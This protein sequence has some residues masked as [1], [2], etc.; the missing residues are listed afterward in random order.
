MMCLHFVKGGDIWPDWE[1]ADP[2]VSS[3]ELSFNDHLWN[4][5][6][7]CY[8]TIPQD[9]LD[10]IEQT[11]EIAYVPG[12][13]SSLVSHLQ[14]LLSDHYAEKLGFV[15]IAS[16]EQTAAEKEMRKFTKLQVAQATWQAAFATGVLYCER[17]CQQREQK[18]RS[19]TKH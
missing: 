12:L 2:V 6:N 19:E 9:V 5:Y 8:D 10:A 1:L 4:W 14:N 16:D 11:S 17:L 18:E 3:K 7:D 15:A 13:C